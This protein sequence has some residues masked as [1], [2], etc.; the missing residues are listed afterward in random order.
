MSEP[1][2]TSPAEVLRAKR[3]EIVDDEG[4][5][6]AVLG[7]REEGIGVV[8]VYDQSGRV[9]ASLEAGE[10]PEQASGLSVFD[11][12]GK[13]RAVVSMDNDPD[14]GSALILLDTEGKQRAVVSL[15]E[16]GQAGLRF[17]AGQ[18]NRAISISAGD[19][20]KLYLMLS[21]EGAPM[22]ALG[23]NEKE[24]QDACSNIVLADNDDR[25]GIV[26]SGRRSGPSIKLTD[27]REKVRASLELGANGEPGLY[28]FDE[29]G[30]TIRQ[31]NAFERVVGERGPVYQVILVGAGLAISGLVGAW[32]ARTASA[33]PG[34]LLAALVTGVVLAA[35][36]V[37]LVVARRRGW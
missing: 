15:K 31:A 22:V 21:G 19:D 33:A 25:A 6:R 30:T 37:L 17:S 2:N 24:G 1:G 10:I 32:I 5:V 27:R 14:R 8:S 18:K 28:H 35:L 9:R 26:I 11:T 13:P 36:V 29:E 34:S 23:L 20:G 7:T 3:L 12:N 4:K 16:G